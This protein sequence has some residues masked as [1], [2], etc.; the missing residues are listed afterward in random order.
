MAGEEHSRQVYSMCTDAFVRISE[1]LQ[2]ELLA[3]EDK[4]LAAMYAVLARLATLSARILLDAPEPE[5]FAETQKLR[6]ETVKLA[7][8][9]RDLEAAIPPKQSVTGHPQV[10]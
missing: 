8:T 1:H 6:E 2:A 4:A 3:E 10:D 7:G 9:V 5:I